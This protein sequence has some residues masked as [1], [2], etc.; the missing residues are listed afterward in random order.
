MADVLCVGHACYDISLPC[1]EFLPEN[2]KVEIAESFESGG[3]PASNAAWLLAQ[4]GICTAFA[5]LI[6]DDLFGRKVAAELQSARVKTELLEMRASHPTPLS[7]II[8]NKSN[9][10][11]SIINRKK[12][13]SFDLNSAAIGDFAK[14]RFLLFDGHELQASLT[15]MRVCPNA[16]TV[17]DAGSLREG[18]EELAGKVHYLLASERFA[19]QVCCGSSGVKLRLLELRRRFPTPLVVAV[20]LGERGLVY[21][22]RD[23]A[24]YHMP[25]YLT[26]T[27]DTTAAGDFWHGAFVYALYLGDDFVLALRF[28]SMTASLKVGRRGTRNAV[29]TP[30]E[31]RAA[32]QRTDCKVNPL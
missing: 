1:D 24:V 10:S 8:V 15:A 11:R 28:A 25:A 30:A 17:L 21:C 26:E 6:G 5:G 4:F 13:A 7:M 12:K 19:K 22:E 23:E 29:P 2:G 31:V 14:S 32:L 20:T 3:G 27:V 16:T 18:T 9:G